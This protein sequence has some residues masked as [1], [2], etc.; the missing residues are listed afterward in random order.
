MNLLNQANNYLE[1]LEA[2]AKEGDH[3]LTNQRLKIAEALILMTS[4]RFQNRAKAEK[5]LREVNEDEILNHELTVDSL[6][7]T[8]DLLLDELRIMGNR[9]VLNELK[10]LTNKLLEISKSQNSALLLAQTY[11]LQSQL[12]LIEL[13]IGRA[14]ELLIEAQLIAE[15]K[16]LNRFVLKMSQEY[17]KL[18]NQAKQWSSLIERDAEI[19]D[20]MAMVNV[21]DLIYKMTRGSEIEIIEHE[22]ENPVFLIILSKEG[23]ILFSRKFETLTRLDDAL[24]GGFVAAIN[25]F[26]TELFETSGHIERIKHQ[27][28]TLL[29][30]FEF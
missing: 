29:Q 16:N 20:I 2:I 30:F 21:E 12:S 22:K 4:S 17:D 5:L 8:C 18:V 19:V 13:N 23:K 9:D 15:E 11:W 14:K 6:L 3:Q 27:D 10:D 24:I 25:S 7:I 28:Y 26:S 1:S